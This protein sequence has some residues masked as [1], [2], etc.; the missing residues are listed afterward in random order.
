MD[1]LNSK[2][3]YGSH[4]FMSKKIVKPPAGLFSVK[5]PAVPVFQWKGGKLHPLLGG[6]F[7]NGTK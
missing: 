4:I 6:E 7:L 5:Q 2:R 3:A 1:Y